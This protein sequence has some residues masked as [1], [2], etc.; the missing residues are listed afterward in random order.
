MANFLKI[1]T[2]EVTSGAKDGVEVSSERALT[3]PIVALLDSSI[4]EVQ[5]VKCAI[6]C[7]EGYVT[8]GPTILG[9]MYWDGNEYQA[10]GG[11]IDKF[12]VALDNGYT[13]ENVGENATWA[14]SVNINNEIGD[15]NVLFWVKISS[16]PDEP[17]AKDNTIALTAKGIVIVDAEG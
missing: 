7:D 17:P 13:Q 1:Y 4:S 8:S 9:F 11:S 2:G 6:R 12:K 15:T 5:Y 10:T 14:N 3:N 16:S